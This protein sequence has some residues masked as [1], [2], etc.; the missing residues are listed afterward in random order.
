LRTSLEQVKHPPASDINSDEHHNSI[1][2]LAAAVQ[3]KNAILEERLMFQ[4]FMNNPTEQQSV[5]YFCK[6][7]TRHTKIGGE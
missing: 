5:D 2:V 4:M 7:K 3:A 1:R 6:M